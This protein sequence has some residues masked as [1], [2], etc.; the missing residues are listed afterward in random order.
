[1]RDWRNDAH[2]PISQRSIDHWSVVHRKLRVDRPFELVSGYR[3]PE[4]NALLRASTTGV[5]KHSLHS[6]GLAADLRLPGRDLTEIAQAAALVGAGGVGIYSE[7]NFVHID[8]GTHRRW[9]GQS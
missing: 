3:S 9:R 4:T 7:S 6:K 1:M 2:M 5:A 8:S